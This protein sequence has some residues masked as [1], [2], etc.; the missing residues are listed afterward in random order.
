MTKLNIEATTQIIA[1]LRSGEYTQGVGKLAKGGCHCVWGVICDVYAKAHPNEEV[2]KQVGDDM[3]TY[4]GYC[5]LPP[6]TAQKWAGISENDVFAVGENEETLMN[7]NDAKNATFPQLA[8]VLEA[9]LAEAKAEEAKTLI[10]TNLTTL[11]DAVALQP[12]EQFDLSN[13]KKESECGTLFCTAG[14]AATMPHF[15]LQGVT[16]YSWSYNR[17]M[18]RVDGID[19]DD[20]PST[21]V[22]FGDKAWKNCF[23]GRDDGGRDGKHHKAG[24]DRWDSVEIS[25][26][27]TDKELALWRLEQQ[28][29]AVKA[30]VVA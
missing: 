1:A 16:L 8:D 4:F 5:A 12:E 27:V 26:D 17:H 7:L 10:I 15:Q 13:Y 23:A 20:S 11:R 18:V 19:V 14:L 30:G 25:A 2:K 9:R 28:I 24:V 3:T 21:D 6:S 22:L 29:A